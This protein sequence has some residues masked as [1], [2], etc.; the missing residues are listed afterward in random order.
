V[1]AAQAAKTVIEE[2]QRRCGPWSHCPA[3][4]APRARVACAVARA[5]ALATG[6]AEADV[7]SRRERRLRAA[8]AKAREE[9][10]AFDA[11]AV[12]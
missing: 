10:V 11:S 6:A 1:E 7:W 12:K 8:A 5:R 2:R 4:P 9:G 3:R